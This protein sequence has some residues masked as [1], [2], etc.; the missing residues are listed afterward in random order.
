MSDSTPPVAV[1]R[2]VDEVLAR[3][4]EV[5]APVAD[6]LAAMPPRDWRLLCKEE[7]GVVYAQ[8][9]ALSVLGWPEGEMIPAQIIG[10]RVVEL[11]CQRHPH[12]ALRDDR[13]A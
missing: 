2:A 9:Q 10:N 8:H 11:F 1:T 12:L 6:A 13:A 3:L 4:D 7:W 5:L